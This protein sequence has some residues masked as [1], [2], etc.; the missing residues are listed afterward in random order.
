MDKVLEE[1]RNE[2]AYQDQKWGEQNH[3]APYWLGILMEEVGEV[4]KG[5]IDNE[6]QENIETEL[7]QCAAV[8]VAAVQSIRRNGVLGK[9]P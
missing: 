8:C 9:K 1:I 5:V 7:I 3:P 6:P 2:R 4:A